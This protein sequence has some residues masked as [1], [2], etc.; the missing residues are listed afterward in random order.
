MQVDTIALPPPKP[1]D[2]LALRESVTTVLLAGGRLQD[3]STGISLRER[4]FTV[5]ISSSGDL[6]ALALDKIGKTVT[7][8]DTDDEEYSAILTA[9][10]C[11]YNKRDLVSVSATL[12]ILGKLGYLLLEGAG[13]LLLEEG[14]RIIL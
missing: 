2:T 10:T 14:G 1:G 5:D 8:M 6:I 12:I 3:A 11:S 4:S 13:Y 9:L 7:F